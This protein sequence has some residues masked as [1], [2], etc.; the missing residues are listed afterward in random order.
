V[1][2]DSYAVFQRAVKEAAA[3]RIDTVLIDTAGRQV[4]DEVLMQELRDIKKAVSADELLL[5]VDAM[6]G[7]EAATLT[8]KFND[9]VGI[10]GAILT[11]LDGDTRGGSAL[12]VRNRHM[13][14]YPKA[15]HM[16]SLL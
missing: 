5:V 11:K 13:S 7:Q 3:R 1:T 12:S 2:R 6:T 4:I 10:S 9:D 14:E 15:C 16:Y 8:A